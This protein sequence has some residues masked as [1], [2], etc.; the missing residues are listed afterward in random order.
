MFK[1]VFKND[2]TAF[3]ATYKAEKWLR[4]NGYSVGSSCV[5]SPQG[6][7]K[8]DFIIAKWRNLSPKERSEMDGTLQAARDQDA[9]LCLKD[10]PK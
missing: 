3:G 4:D 6:V 2:G 8:G 5:F 1:K 10:A 9:V 7:M